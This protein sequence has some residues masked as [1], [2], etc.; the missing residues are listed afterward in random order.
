MI[1]RTLFLVRMLM[2]EFPFDDFHEGKY[3]IFSFYYCSTRYQKCDIGLELEIGLKMSEITQKKTDDRKYCRQ[4]M[5]ITKLG[6][7]EE[8]FFLGNAESN[9]PIVGLDKINLDAFF[10]ESRYWKADNKQ[11]YTREDAVKVWRKYQFEHESVVINPDNCL[12]VDRSK[13]PITLM[14]IGDHIP[15]NP[16]YNAD[17]FINSS[18]EQ[19]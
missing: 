1:A 15:K 12:Y 5:G 10:D 4:G 16:V 13:E 9:T 18:S 19:S 17:I 3:T 7:Y 8:E 11:E 14:N 2:Q 6:P